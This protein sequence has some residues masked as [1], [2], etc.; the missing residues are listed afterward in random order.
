MLREHQRDEYD[1]DRELQAQGL[2]RLERGVGTFV[3]AEPDAPTVDRRDYARIA[4]K[5][6]DLVR[7]CREAGLTAREMTQLV[8]STWKETSS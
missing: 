2:L 5:A 4:N 6:R 7:L 1:N 3:A 8:D